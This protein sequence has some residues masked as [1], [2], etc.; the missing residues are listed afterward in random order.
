MRRDYNDN[1]GNLFTDQE[2]LDCL[3]ELKYEASE[4]IKIGRQ[5]E[6]LALLIDFLIEQNNTS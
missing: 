4:A 1:K 5:V 6:Q 3:S 2:I